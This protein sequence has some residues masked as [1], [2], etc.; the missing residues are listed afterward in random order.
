[1]KR[2][3]I[4]NMVSRPER[5]GPMCRKIGCAPNAA[6]AKKNFIFWKNKN[7]RIIRLSNRFFKL[8]LLQLRVNAGMSFFGA[9]LFASAALFTTVASAALTPKPTAT[10]ENEQIAQL[11]DQLGVQAL[12]AQTPA[13]LAAASEAETQFLGAKP[14][15]ANWRRDLETQLKPQALL[16]SVTN[17]LRERYRA[18]TFQSAQQRLQEPI[19]KR[20]RYF[21]LA[22][23]QPGAEK[24]LKDFLIQNGLMKNDP[25]H[26]TENENIAARRVLLQEIDTASASSLLT[27]TLQSAIAARVR[28]AATRS[29][30]DV[31]L[32]SDEIAER[33]RYLVPLA[34]DY[35]LYD[36]RYLRDDELHDYRDILRDDNVQWLLDVCRQ[37]VLM[38]IVG[39]IT[40]PPTAQ[41]IATTTPSSSTP[42]PSKLPLTQPR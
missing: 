42:P 7:G 11:L 37:A 18:E 23:T 15:P 14:Q 36:Y 22:M 3:A 24:N 17:F 33:Q 2:W 35:L 30:I 40:P 20:A 6:S 41:P 10:I 8:P 1:M 12:L 19:A 9:L 27:A 25:K 34:I 16:Q 26:K 5:F 13:V 38:A 31:A 28:Q 32:L 29:A 39:E 4:P 21:D